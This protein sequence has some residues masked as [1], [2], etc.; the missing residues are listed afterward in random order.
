MDEALLASLVVAPRDHARRRCLA[1]SL[2]PGLIQ[3]ALD[4]PV[5][6]GSPCASLAS[7]NLAS[8]KIAPAWI[9][10]RLDSYLGAKKAPL[11]KTALAQNRTRLDSHSV[12]FAPR[13][14]HTRLDSRLGVVKGDTP[15]RLSLA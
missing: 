1:F 14:I 9:G 13:W 8:I 11:L 5:V 2:S 12:R 3:R 7:L 4:L 15:R 10:T 6:V